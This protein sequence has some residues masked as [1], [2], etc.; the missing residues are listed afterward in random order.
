[1]KMMIVAGSVDKI[2]FRIRFISRLQQKGYKVFIAAPFSENDTDLR[3]QL[4]NEEIDVYDLP[5]ERTT[6]NPL[7]D[8]KTFIFLYKLMKRLRP[9]HIISFTIK[10][11][12]YASI[13]AKFTRV[14]NRYAMITGLGYVFIYRE[15]NNIFRRILI[16]FIKKLYKYALADVDKV[17]FQ[18]PDDEKLL[19]ETK[20]LS[21]QKKTAILNGSGVDLDHFYFSEL[22]SD[23]PRFLLIS[24]LLGNKGIRE[25][26]AAARII[27]A[28]YPK[29]I[30]ELVGWQDKNP[31]AIEQFELDQWTQ[32]G[33]LTY[34][35]FKDDVRK[36]IIDCSVF[37]LPSYREGTPRAVLE[38]MAMGRAIITTDAPGCRETVVNGD[39]GF[40]VPVKS[41]NALVEA[42]EFFIKDSHLPSIMGM[43]SRQIAEEKYNVEDVDSA[44]FDEMNMS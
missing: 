35:G 13:A 36:N 20:V 11:V 33:I 37:V 21:S 5:L 39:N 40:L 10:S 12:I 25:Y 1:M 43:R 22:T 38:S 31:D 29:V 44:M 34:L 18:N 7:V 26:A 8:L 17:F 6:I 14:P 32:E 2:K 27:R 9:S 42:M 4:I 19:K 41:V 23:Q 30:F 15:R 28:K 16:K 24:R 3:H